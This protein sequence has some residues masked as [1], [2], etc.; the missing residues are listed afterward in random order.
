MVCCKSRQYRL[1]IRI[2]HHDKNEVI[3]IL[4]LQFTDH[5]YLVDRGTEL[6]IMPDHIAVLLQFIQPTSSGQHSHIVAPAHQH[7]G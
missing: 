1:E 3:N 6:E 2:F 5:I 7:M 4:R